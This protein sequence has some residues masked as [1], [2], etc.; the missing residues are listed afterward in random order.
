MVDPVL[1]VVM[2]ILAVLLLYVSVYLLALYCHPDDGGFG[3]SLICKLIVV[4]WGRLWEQLVK[5]VKPCD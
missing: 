3:A 4:R 5:G 1:I 2:V